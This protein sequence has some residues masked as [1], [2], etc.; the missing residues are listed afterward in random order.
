MKLYQFTIPTHT[1]SGLSYEAARKA[2]ET[3]A[4]RIAG[5]YTKPDSYSRGAWRDPATGRVYL[6]QVI[7]YAIAC[8]R[9]VRDVLE[10]TFWHLFP[11]Q[12]ALLVTCLGDATIR[13][14]P[15]AVA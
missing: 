9:N 10:V 6:D 1:N 8:E 5:G 4:L 7:P 11:D 14:R 2:W 15:S 13:E 3:E 12:E